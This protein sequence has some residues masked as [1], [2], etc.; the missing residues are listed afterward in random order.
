MDFPYFPQQTTWSRCPNVGNRCRSNLQHHANF[1]LTKDFRR[2]HEAIQ[3]ITVL[4]LSQGNCVCT[5]VGATSSANRYAFR[6]S[7]SEKWGEEHTKLK[8]AGH[9]EQHFLITAMLPPLLRT[10]K[11]FDVL[12]QECW[13]YLLESVDF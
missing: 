10:N 3:N 7:R 11:N 4:I 13:A 6:R 8:K 5:R 9:K 2:L 1:I 12:P